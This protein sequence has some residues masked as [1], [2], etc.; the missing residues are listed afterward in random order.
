MNSLG[1]YFLAGSAL[2]LDED[3]GMVALRCPTRHL[4]HIAHQRTFGYHAAKIVTPLG[5]LHRVVNAYA[6][7]QHFGRAVDGV[8]HVGDV[9]WLDQIVIGTEL[10]GFHNT[11]HHMV[12]AH[13]H[14]DGG[15]GKLLGLTQHF[16][17]IDAGQYDVEQG[18]V[19]LFLGERGQRFFTAHGQKNFEALALQGAPNSAHGERFVIDNQDG[20]RHN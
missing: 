12:G 7:R 9:K 10:H 17:T 11:I 16:D 2:A 6:E 15:R 20:I 8:Y 18:Q 13:H 1:Q 4:Q 3:S 14:D 5:A 19:R